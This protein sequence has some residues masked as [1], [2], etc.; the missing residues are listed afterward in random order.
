MLVVQI[1]RAA[2][3]GQPTVVEVLDDPLLDLFRALALCENAESGLPS[4]IIWSER[5]HVRS[6]NGPDTTVPPAHHDLPEIIRSSS[7]RLFT[8]GKVSTGFGYDDHPSLSRQSRSA[9]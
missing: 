4:G 7:E 6:R 3:E 5:T 8:T 9:L 2:S 1:D